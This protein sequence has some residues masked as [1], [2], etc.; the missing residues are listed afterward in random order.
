MGVGG[1]GVGIGGDRGVRLVLASEVMK[2]VGVCD[3]PWF[4]LV[5]VRR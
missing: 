1:I 2:G 4:S 3:V 5:V